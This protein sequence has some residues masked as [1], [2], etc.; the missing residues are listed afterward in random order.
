MR[1]ASSAVLVIQDVKVRWLV[2]RKI[3]RTCYRPET[4]QPAFRD[5]CLSFCPFLWSCP[6]RVNGVRVRGRWRA[7]QP[8][9]KFVRSFPPKGSRQS[10]RCSS[11]WFSSRGYPVVVNTHLT[12]EAIQER[13]PEL[14]AVCVPIQAMRFTERV[15]LFD[16]LGDIIR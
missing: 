12:D 6:K 11:R 1:S 5:R 14:M 15:E 9:T 7:Q 10:Q 2:H 13:L 8:A 3:M 4:V 16:G